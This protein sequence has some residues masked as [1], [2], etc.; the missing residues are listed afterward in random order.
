[1]GNIDIS[2]GVWEIDAMKQEPVY[3]D[4]NATTAPGAELREKLSAWFDLWGNPSSIHQWGR[5]SK[6]LMRDSRRSMASALGVHPLEIIFTSGGSEANNLA[7]FG[8]LRALE[9]QNSPRKKI[10]VGAIEHP[11]AVSYTHLTLPTKA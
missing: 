10:L 9:K 11:S 7:L 2:P 8:S 3:L 4:F 1:M 5:G 6:R